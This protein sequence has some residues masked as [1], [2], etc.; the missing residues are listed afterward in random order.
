ME[1][2]DRLSVSL[3]IKI[4]SPRGSTRRS[5]GDVQALEL[6]LQE[7]YRVFREKVTA[8]L[9]RAPKLVWHADD[10]IFVK[11]TNNATQAQYEE[12]RTSTAGLRVQLRLWSLALRRRGG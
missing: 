2:L 3:A 10:P 1:L 5:H 12:L 6:V 7:G 4:G 9:E 8:I 11:P